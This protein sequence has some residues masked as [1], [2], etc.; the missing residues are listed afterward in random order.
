MQFKTKQKAFNHAG[1]KYLKEGYMVVLDYSKEFKEL[2]NGWYEAEDKEESR[3]I[4]EQDN[5]WEI[6]DLYYY[7]DL[8]L[9]PKEEDKVRIGM[10]AF[11]VGWHKQY[12]NWLVEKAKCNSGSYVFVEYITKEEI[13]NR[14]EILKQI[15]RR[16]F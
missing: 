4:I 1:R 15:A 5:N 11:I 9:F 3:I 7:K 14:N 16:M 12:L 10:A 13:I 6:T 2:I 8:K